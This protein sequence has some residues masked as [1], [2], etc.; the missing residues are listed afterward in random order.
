MVSSR[1]VLSAFK[2]A[3]DGLSSALAMLFGFLNMIFTPVERLFQMVLD[4]ADRGMAVQWVVDLS[5]ALGALVFVFLTK[6]DDIGSLGTGNGTSGQFG[7]AELTARSVV[8]VAS[9]GLLLVTTSGIL[10]KVF[11][12]S[13]LK[14]AVGE[15]KVTFSS[16]YDAYLATFKHGLHSLMLV[17]TSLLL[18]VR[19]D[20]VTLWSTTNTT[21][22]TP[23]KDDSG[24]DTFLWVVFIVLLVSKFFSEGRHGEDAREMK[25]KQEVIGTTVELDSDHRFKHAR[26]SALTVATGLLVFLVVNSPAT[27]ESVTDGVTDVVAQGFFDIL[28]SKPIALSLA[29][30]ILVVAL[31]RIAGRAEWVYG[32]AGG[33]VVTGA[34]STLNLIFAGWALAGD[35]D[36]PYEE[37]VVALGVIFLDAMRVGYGQVVPE[38]GIVSDS[39]KVFLRL[40][41]AVIGLLLFRYITLTM[42]GVGVTAVKSLLYGVAAASAL[43][44]IV[45]ISYIGKDL[46]KTST[47]HHYRELASTGLL[48]ASMYL[49]K[50]NES[51]ESMIYF[52]LAILS[53][54]LD[55]IMD[56]LMT[57]KPALSYLTW[58]KDGEGVDSPTSDNPRTWLTLLGLLASLV[59]ASLVMHDQF[60][61]IKL[62]ANVTDASGAEASRPLDKELSDSMIVAVTFIA[63]HIA[64]V[65]VGLVSEIPGAEAA[66]VGALSRSKFVRFAVTTTVLCSLAVAM[67]TFGWRERTSSDGAFGHLVSAL[68]SY[69]FADVV[70]RELL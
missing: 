35:Q 50:Q 43:I 19:G 62:G 57:G 69:L 46:Y 55:S 48:L 27:V 15:V 30:Y 23:T 58:D 14:D 67:G 49:W 54:F 70:G 22:V 60:E 18:A 39:R 47:E 28:A 53:R 24:V 33:L 37:I 32:G 56:F 36:Q 38:V 7:L 3:L 16:E 1:D 31:E 10:G 40:S 64:V 44:K 8:F 45:G 63:V 5:L 61:D 12:L 29:I 65:I 25:T 20:R 6:T 26:G 34:V 4:F 51:T 52:V 68:V 66:A 11:D 17:A 42:D 21:L 59:F 13:A 41:Q 9:L 2:P